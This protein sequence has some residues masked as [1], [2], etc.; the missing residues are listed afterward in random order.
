MKLK[1]FR[2]E[3]CGQTVI[4][5]PDF[6]GHAFR[7]QDLQLEANTIRTH[8]QKPG[9]RHLVIDLAQMDYF[10][11][12]FISAVVSM[13]RETKSRGGQ[14]CFCSSRPQ[15]LEVLN[16]TGLCKVWPHFETRQAALSAVPDQEAT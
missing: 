3:Q 11:S 6:D 13:L 2:W 12:E 1:L 9:Q 4:V 8:M 16:S 14:A 5:V 15:T 10:G 7:Y